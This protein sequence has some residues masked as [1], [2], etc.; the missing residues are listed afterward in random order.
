MKNS[1]YDIRDI[2]KKIKKYN[3]VSFDIFD[4]L[5]KRNVH[6][7][8]D[9]FKLVAIEYEKRT[10]KKLP[11][12]EN[13][14]I[15]AE[16][17]AKKQNN[18][19]EPN[20][21]DIY[22]F[23]NLDENKFNLN[24]IKQIEINMELIF[25]QQNINFYPIY[26]YCLENHKKIVIISDMYLNKKYIRKI[27]QKAQIYKY[28]YLFLSNDINLNKHNG[29][30]YSYILK[31]LKISPREIIHIGDSKRGD[32]I[33]AKLKGIRS[34][35][36][37]KKTYNENLQEEKKLKQKLDYNI[38]KMYIEN[39]I[40]ISS[41]EY[42]KIGYKVLGPL[43]YG[44]SKWLLE[45]VK[46]NNIKKIF[47]L[48]REGNLLKKATDIINNNLDIIT[49]YIFISRKSVRPVLLDIES[50]DDLKSIIK[51][52]PTTT[53][54]KLLMDLD[55]YDKKHIEIVKSQ[56]YDEETVIE[57]IANIEEFFNIFKND[58][59]KK[60]EKE[61]KNV[62]GYLESV[63][64]NDNIA[65][66]DVGWSG[67]MQKALH[68]IY[69][70]YRIAGFYIATTNDIND[71]E[72]YS[73]I[74]DYNKIRP[75]V[76]LFE[77]MFLAQHGTT[78]KYKLINNRYIPVLDE[79]E[80]SSNEKDIIIKIQ[81][82]ALDFVKSFNLS[83]ISKIIELEKDTAFLEMENLGLH[84]GLKD[85]QIFKDIPYIETEKLKLIEGK[86]L[87]YYIFH[88]KRIKK[89]LYSSGW[90]IGFLK[91]VFKINLNYVS[92]Y[93]FLINYKEKKNEKK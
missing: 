80:Y 29:K 24:L 75:F 28:D 62:L 93:N 26:K 6:K 31:E 88:V 21:D 27:L 81:E 3:Y 25:C 56:H 11:N 8:S 77:N 89:D 58:I 46:E 12:F 30:I 10:N 73:Y 18:Y 41:N 50:F 14:R 49:E 91:N 65:I 79:Y 92:I 64:I 53:V 71:I 55:L 51:I 70:K 57:E 37:P 22:K 61:K 42:Y 7:P 36:I 35:L 33:Q 59:K 78:L 32:Y 54:K 82:G 90:K 2:I 72:K 83:S 68:V 66:S 17:R 1:I 69:E 60:S 38:L 13:I 85:I 4:T 52:K 5:V 16:L 23:I 84:P 76:H 44:Y 87:P 9:I 74:G 34:I 45:K 48:A 39:N 43:L 20:L 63:G 19:E 15:E 47:F 86:S 40:D 67:T